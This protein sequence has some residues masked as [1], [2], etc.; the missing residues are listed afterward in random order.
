MCEFISSTP[1]IQGAPAQ[2]RAIYTRYMGSPGRWSP[3]GQGGG[4]L[5]GYGQASTA[6][7]GI[8]PVGLVLAALT[9]GAIWFLHKTAKAEAAEAKE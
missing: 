7:G 2:H 8:A 5:S 1:A 9:A 3:T 4:Y 6:I